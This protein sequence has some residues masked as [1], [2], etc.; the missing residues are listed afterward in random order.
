MNNKSGLDNNPNSIFRASKT[1]KNIINK[2]LKKIEDAKLA[3][4]QSLIPNQNTGKSNVESEVNKSLSQFTLYIKQLTTLIDLFVDYINGGVFGAGVSGGSRSSRQYARVVRRDNFSSPS[5]VVRGSQIHSA[6]VGQSIDSDSDS[7]SEESEMWNRDIATIAGS[8][9]DS[10]SSDSD[11]DGDGGDG[12]DGD[13]LIGEEVG[14][15]DDDDGLS[16]LT[17]STKSESKYKYKN[18]HL[19]RELARISNL[20][21]QA[22]SLWEDYIRPNIFYLSK[23]SLSK[24][25]NS[26]L[27]A[28]FEDSIQ[29]FDDL[30]YDSAITDRDYPELYR[31]YQNVTEDLD[32][33]FKTIE[34]DIK[35]VSG[36]GTGQSSDAVVGAGFLHFPSPYNNYMHHTKTKYLM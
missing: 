14:S 10:D 29:G 17:D 36:I 13:S 5:G 9:S 27:I 30:L 20:A 3:Q 25:L 4:Q 19:A 32:E 8:E 1:V 21:Q 26:K 33:L 24:F 11:S 15:F 16:A 7:E 31:V 35:R 12:G 2:N 22:T 34:T 28:D 23:I 18:I 6:P